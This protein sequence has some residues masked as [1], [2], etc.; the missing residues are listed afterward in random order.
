MW[1]GEGLRER[2]KEETGGDGTHLE[3][4]SGGVLD[5]Y[6]LVRVEVDMMS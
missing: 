6:W 2:S 4:R 3:L 1:F 5:I